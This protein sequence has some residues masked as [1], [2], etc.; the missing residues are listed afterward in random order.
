MRRAV[1]SPAETE[2]NTEIMD[3]LALLNISKAAA[4]IEG[5]SELCIAE[6]RFEGQPSGELST[7]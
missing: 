5:G 7:E 1:P 6:A 4:S 3:P 2:R